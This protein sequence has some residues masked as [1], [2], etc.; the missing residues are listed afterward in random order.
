MEGP[1][2]Y[3][4]FGRTIQMWNRWRKTEYF[5]KP[6]LLRFFD[7]I[8]FFPV[9]NAELLEARE[10]FVH[11]RYPLKIEKTQFNLAAHEALL[12]QNEGEIVAFKARQQAAFEA[13]RQH[14]REQGLDS[15]VSDEA[16]EPPSPEEDIP[17]GMR[18]IRAAATGMVWKVEVEQGQLIQ[19][20]ETIIIIESMKMEIAIPSTSGGVVTRLFCQPG[21]VVKAGQIVALIKAAP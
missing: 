18:P 7:Q 14:W 1:G 20:G 16:T 2:G 19:A 4:L 13:E 9:S 12:K 21:H 10:A 3:Q 11:G 15:Y 5:E 17:P 8:R 6:W